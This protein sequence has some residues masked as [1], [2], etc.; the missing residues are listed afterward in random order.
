MKKSWMSLFGEM[1]LGLAI[2]YFALD[3][4]GWTLVSVGFHCHLRL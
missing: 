3:Y 4:N 1:I 2:S